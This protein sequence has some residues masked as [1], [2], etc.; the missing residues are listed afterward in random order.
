MTHE[1]SDDPA[2]EPRD[3]NG[4]VG[5][6]NKERRVEQQDQCLFR[7]DRREGDAKE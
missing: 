6:E 2:I 1:V 7:A 5:A 3:Q 4:K